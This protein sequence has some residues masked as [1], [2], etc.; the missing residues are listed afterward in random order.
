MWSGGSF[1][2]IPKRV[3]VEIPI[4]SYYRL[5]APGAGQFE[6]TLIVVDEDSDLHFIEGCSAPK[7]TV[8]NL[9]AGKRGALCKEK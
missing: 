8:S 7:Y 2:Y 1:I 5:N 4:Q 3:S 6:H 9:H